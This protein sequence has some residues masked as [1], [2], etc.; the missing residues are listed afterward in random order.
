MTQ[1][2]PARSSSLRR[3]SR[4]NRVDRNR[5]SAPPSRSAGRGRRA[6][7]PDAAR[8]HG[9]VRRTAGG[10]LEPEPVVDTQ[11]ADQGVEAEPQTGAEPEFPQRDVAHGCEDVAGV[12]EPDA[13][14]APREGKA[15]FLAQHQQRAAARRRTVRAERTQALFR[16]A[17]HGVAAARE[18]PLRLDQPAAVAGSQ[19]HRDRV[20]T[21]RRP[22][23]PAW[24]MVTTGR[25]GVNRAATAAPWARTRPF[26]WRP[27]R[28][29]PASD[30]PEPL[31]G[32]RQ[33]STLHLRGARPNGLVDRRRA[34]RHRRRP[35]VRTACRTAACVTT[36]C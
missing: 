10:P 6:G 27:A 29:P 9:T 16:V 15:H 13:G 30:R 34:A 21:T 11:Q 28:W 23:Q 12:H 7:P 22:D 2:P 25:Y 33:Q 35:S 4:S 36:G 19:A 31:R 26:S 14:D 18:E 5:G 24:S 20:R 1:A 32:G 3:P 17:A 8:P